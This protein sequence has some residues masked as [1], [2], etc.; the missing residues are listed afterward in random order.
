MVSARNA[1][2]KPVA[3]DLQRIFGD[4]LEAVVAYGWRHTG[5]VPSLAL[6]QS[7]R[8]STI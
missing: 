8:G 6:V 1:A 2:V 7:H 4:R 3:D 5:P